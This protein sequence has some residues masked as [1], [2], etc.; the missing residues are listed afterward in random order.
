MQGVLN[1]MNT[2]LAAAENKYT[3]SM[4]TA[5]D[6]YS[7]ETC[8]LDGLY[9]DAMNTISS[10]GTIDASFY[11]NGASSVNVQV[12]FV[13]GTKVRS[14]D[15]VYKII[16][17]LLAKGKV[18]TP[19]QDDPEGEHDD[20]EILETYHNVPQPVWLLKIENTKTNSTFEL[21]AT[22]EHPFYVPD[23][24]WVQVN[25]LELGEKFLN[26]KGEKCLVLIEKEFE[27]EPVPVFNINVNDAHT[28]FVGENDDDAVL[29][30]NQCY[31]WEVTKGFGDGLC[32]GV[33][34]VVNGASGAVV[35]TVTLGYRDYNGPF[36]MNEKDIA[37]GGNISQGIARASGEIAIGVATGGVASA[38][39]K[40][41]NISKGAKY[42][43]HAVNIFDATGNTL[44][45]GRGSYDMSQ[46]GVS[47]GNSVQVLGGGVGLAG[48]ITPYLKPLVKSAA[49]N[50]PSI[51]DILDNNGIS[52][53]D[54][55]YVHFG[56]N[57]YSPESWCFLLVPLW[58]S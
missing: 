10:G 1:N 19:R 55:A 9:N 5:S 7:S 48:N 6:V 27:F 36:E 12:C 44:N 15:N 22:K 43:A 52:I 42:A 38:A 32:T 37:Y 51:G 11:Q 49:P 56:H 14:D 18:K 31:W 33:K 41:A 47:F 25:A 30:H 16:D 28:Y 2:S 53:N 17:G 39:S 29:V 13:A 45:V 58:P 21:R 57:P 34:G 40:T 54:D 35:S 24:G 4:K 23:K 20:Y 50:S 8:R 46:K 3:A 26:A